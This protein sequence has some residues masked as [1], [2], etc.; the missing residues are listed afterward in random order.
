MRTKLILAP[1]EIPWEKIGAGDVSYSRTDDR[2]YAA[3]LVFSYPDLVLLESSTDQGRASFPY[4]PS[5][6]TFREAPI[7]L[8]AFSKLTTKPDLILADGQ[9]IAHPRSMGIAAHLGLLLDLPSIGCAKSRL[10]GTDAEIPLDRGSVAP[11]NEEGRTVGMIV[12]TRAG[13]KPVYISPGHKMDLETSVKTILS[14]CRGY[15]LP[16]PLRQAH[17]LVNRLRGEK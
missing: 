15:R 16:E 8:K 14:L 5:L 6:L 9:G 4:I 2:G 11:L 3:F 12:R 13:V 7:L 1:P 10:Y 17:I